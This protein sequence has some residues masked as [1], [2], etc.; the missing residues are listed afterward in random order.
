MIDL[1]AALTD[2]AAHL[3]HPA[4]DDLQAAVL[5]AH[6]DR[7][8]EPRSGPS[9]FPIS[10]RARGRSCSDRRHA[11]GDRADARTR[12]PTGSA[13]A[14]S[15]SSGTEHP[16]PTGS[17]AL[18]VPGAPD[19]TPTGAVARR[20]AAARRAAAFTIA[21]PRAPSVGPLL[22]VDLDRRVRGGL[23]ALRYERFTL[24]EIATDG[25]AAIVGKFLDPRARLESV[26]VA[27]APGFWITGAHQIGYLSRSG[28]IE[29]DTVRR[30]GPVL[31]WARDGVTYR[32][33]GIA[34]RTEAQAI[35]AVIR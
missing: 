30:S 9:S 7:R 34:R 17:S 33:E 29:T 3:D 12:S 2:L 32:I 1:E 10:P 23:V 4:G 15:R 11:V 5:R 16:L 28:N 14:R 22:G 24:V 35:A 26:M 8:P 18:T 21:T 6:L 20:L 19:S 27:G 25:N 13:S 31:L